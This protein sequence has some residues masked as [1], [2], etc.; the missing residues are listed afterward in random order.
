MSVD[1][2]MMP[3]WETK[4]VQYP[5]VHPPTA[6]TEPSSA[7]QASR[8]WTLAVVGHSRSSPDGCVSCLPVRT[9]RLDEVLNRRAMRGCHQQTGARD[10]FFWPSGRCLRAGC[11]ASCH[12]ATVILGSRDTRG[13]PNVLS[14]P[15]PAPGRCWSCDETLQRLARTRLGRRD[16]YPGAGRRHQRAE[17]RSQ[18][19][20]APWKWHGGSGRR[21]IQARCCFTYSVQQQP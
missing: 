3:G 18:H 20:Q 21:S 12:C 10:D 7:I 2:R 5:P 9:L 16:G 4:P 11:Q 17:E 14:S 13:Y 6:F 8:G 15:P 1:L 19:R